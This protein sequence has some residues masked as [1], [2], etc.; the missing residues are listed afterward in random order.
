[1]VMVAAGSTLRQSTARHIRDFPSFYRRHP[2]ST[3]FRNTGLRF[4]K[5]LKL[6]AFDRARRRRDVHPRPPRVPLTRSP[7]S[8]PST[9]SSSPQPTAPKERMKMEKTADATRGQRD[10][11]RMGCVRGARRPL[12]TSSKRP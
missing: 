7:I 2:Q 5:Y 10:V 11:R 4:C 8:M 6:P 1:M 9:P 3:N 12:A